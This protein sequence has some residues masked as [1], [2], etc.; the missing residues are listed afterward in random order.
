MQC[1]GV[2]LSYGEV[3]VSDQVVAY[4][5]RSL[6]GAT[7]RSTRF[8]STCRARQFATR[9]LWF[10]PPDELMEEAAATSSARCT[11]PSTR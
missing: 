3:E 8:R 2:E 6:P 10:V 7:A 1:C 5:R 4:E 11:P 9:A